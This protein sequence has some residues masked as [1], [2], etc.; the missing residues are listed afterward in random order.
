M[1]L[2]VVQ[3]FGLQEIHFRQ[4]PEGPPGPKGRH[5]PAVD[6]RCIHYIAREHEIVKE[7]VIGLHEQQEIREPLDFIQQLGRRLLLVVPTIKD[8]RPCYVIHA[9]KTLIFIGNKPVVGGF[10]INPDGAQPRIADRGFFIKMGEMGR[11]DEG[12]WA[13][14]WRGAGDEP[15]GSTD[16]K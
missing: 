16:S 14:L 10:T 3:F 4:S 5:G 6:M 8:Q 9:G 11:I 7:A 13:I 1:A 12:G 15:K 2:P